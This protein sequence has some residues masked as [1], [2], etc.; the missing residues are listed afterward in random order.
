[1]V[2]EKVICFIDGF[3]LYHAIDNLKY[4]HL[5]WVNL[6]SLAKV[7]IRPKSQVLLD[8]YYFSAYADWLPA[9]KKRHIQ[10]VKALETSG[11]TIVMGKFKAKDRR[12]PK[13]SVKWVGHEEKE[14][15]ANIAL[16]ILNL[17]NKDAYDHAFLISNDSDLA[18]AIRMVLSNFPNK[19]ITSIVPPHYLH[20]N[21]L[22]QACSEKA[23]IRIEHLERC[24]LPPTI[25][26]PKGHL[27]TTRPLE[28]KPSILASVFKPIITKVL[29]LIRFMVTLASYRLFEAT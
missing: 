2:Q 26:D 25:F 29:D 5:K 7:F 22:I 23:K 6:R 8:V 20:S 13:C 11:V 15:D 9:S 27:I 17:A 24:L 12:C 14:S 1:M 4:P 28:Y 21:E 10:Y 18:P 19:K 16:H 3:N